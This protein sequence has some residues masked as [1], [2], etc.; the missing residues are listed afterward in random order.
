M[1]KVLK[2]FTDLQ[3][4]NFAYDEGDIYPRKDLTVS[5]ERLAELSSSNNKQGEP[6]IK[7]VKEAKAPAQAEQAEEAPKKTAAKKTTKKPA[8]V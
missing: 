7:L 4:N 1:Y 3:D 8:T 2:F 6:L 5:E